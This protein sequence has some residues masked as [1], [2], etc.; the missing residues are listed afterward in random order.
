MAADNIFSALMDALSVTDRLIKSGK[1]SGTDLVR[2]QS[3]KSSL[4]NMKGTA[5]A[6]RDYT[7]APKPA[8]DNN[9]TAA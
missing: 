6:L 4:A 1:L 5:F 7:Y 3:V 2:A 8:N 9:S